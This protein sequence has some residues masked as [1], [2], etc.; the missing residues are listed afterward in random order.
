VFSVQET[1]LLFSYLLLKLIAMSMTILAS[2]PSITYAPQSAWKLGNNGTM[3]TTDSGATAEFTFN[4]VSVKVLG[5]IPSVKHEDTLPVSSYTLDDAKPVVFNATDF[6]YGQSLADFVF[7]QSVPG[8]SSGGH[9]LVI[10]AV[11][12][13]ADFILGSI[14][15]VTNF[16]S[17]TSTNPEETPTSSFL[18]SQTSTAVSSPAP[19]APVGGI[20]AGVVV[21]LGVLAAL[22][23]FLVIR[24]KRKQRT[25]KLHRVVT[26]FIASRNGTRDLNRAP[27]PEPRYDFDDEKS[28]TTAPGPSTHVA[29]RGSLYKPG[30]S[31]D[32][33]PMEYGYGG[34]V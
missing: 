11:E 18:P 13:Q 3:T 29:R 21:G 25:V 4:G 5:T 14:V 31:S 15:Y 6:S 9:R 27:I 2:D 30:S 10:T 20:V 33:P 28:P 23:A 34:G 1:V 16:P 24:R 7:Y 26:P 19:K 12:N 22:V 32:L 17:S 8:L